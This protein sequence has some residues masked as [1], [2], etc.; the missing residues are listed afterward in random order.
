MRGDKGRI[1]SSQIEERATPATGAQQAVVRTRQAVASA[2][3]DSTGMLADGQPTSVTMGQGTGKKAFTHKYYSR[4]T[5]DSRVLKQTAYPDIAYWR[6]H[7]REDSLPTGAG[8]VVTEDLAKSQGLNRNKPRAVLSHYGYS[9]CWSEK[10]EAGVTWTRARSE[11]GR[12]KDVQQ[13]DPDKSR[14]SF[15]PEGL[16]VAKDVRA[17]YTNGI[18][19]GMAVQQER[20]EKRWSHV[21]KVPYGD[22]NM[23]FFSFM[24]NGYDLDPAYGK[25]TRIDVSRR[26]DQ[27]VKYTVSRYGDGASSQEPGAVI[28]RNAFGEVVALTDPQSPQYKAVFRY[29]A[30]GRTVLKETPPSLHTMRTEDMYAQVIDVAD[31]DRHIPNH[32]HAGNVGAAVYYVLGDTGVIPS[33]RG[34]KSADF[35]YR[36][37]VVRIHR[38]KLGKDDAATLQSDIWKVLGRWGELSLKDPKSARR[39]FDAILQSYKH[40]TIEAA[41]DVCDFG[42]PLGLE[43]H[44]NI[45]FRS[46]KFKDVTVTTSSGITFDGCELG[47]VTVVGS[48]PSLRIQNCT[49]T[50]KLTFQPAENKPNCTTAFIAHNDFATG[51][52]PLVMPTSAEKAT[53]GL[54]RVGFFNNVVYEDKSLQYRSV[55]RGSKLL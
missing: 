30:F 41:T 42:I 27:P 47:N 38:A 53:T 24:D 22:P 7:I 1:I 3:Y 29:D 49:I 25:P 18:G 28:A 20:Y 8:S 32:W 35:R 10:P 21:L 40:L 26:G 23:E 54:L 51:A 43:N 52:Y 46:L 17:D 34:P 4:Y 13:F 31:Q 37:Y 9:K 6:R 48:C 5:A 55:S 36:D 50:G 19:Q 39:V 2:D 11:S 14:L 33:Y 15:V 12:F 45:T 16:S 44:Y